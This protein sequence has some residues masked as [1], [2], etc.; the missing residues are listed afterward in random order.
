[1]PDAVFDEPR[2][3]A[4]YDALDPDRSDLD[5]YVAMVEEFHARSV[6]DLGCGT[7]VFAITLAGR[8]IDV[9]GVDPAGASIDVARAKPGADRVTWIHGDATVIPASVSVDAVT[10]TANVAQVF[11]TDDDWL[12]TLAA[13]HAALRPGGRLIFES[14]DPARR[15]WEGWTEE[16]TRSTTEI[17]GIGRVT[18]WVQVTDVDGD[19]V[20]FES[21]NVFEA[22]GTVITSRSTLRF[23]SRDQ[24]ESSLTR[25][26]FLVDGVRDA[27]DRPGRELVFVARRA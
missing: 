9:I 1:L 20:T 11:V 24:I 10:M 13:I 7:G 22:D 17:P 5:P 3:A 27:P 18:D 15:A 26:G 2:L 14:R 19:L 4:I 6:V 23:R 8:G 16:R 21:P 12:A 25:S